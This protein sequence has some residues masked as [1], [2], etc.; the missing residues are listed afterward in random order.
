MAISIYHRGQDFFEI[1]KLIKN[2]VPEYKLRFLNL[3]AESPFN[4]R[5]LLDYTR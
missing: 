5:V 3:N 4:E 1:P 2:L